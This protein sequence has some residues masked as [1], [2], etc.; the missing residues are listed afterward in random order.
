MEQQFT[1]S[2]VERMTGATRQQLDY[3]SR[4]R[5]VQPR[6]RWGE[7]FFNFS[8]LVAVEA[9]RRLTAQRVP[10]QRLSRVVRALERQ[11]G[12]APRPLSSLHISVTGDE[13]IVR[14]P[15]PNGRPIE[16][17]T[18]QFVLDFDTAPLEK[19]VHLL[20]SRTAEEWFELAMT[21]DGNKETMDKAVEAY[22]QVIQIAPDW[23]EAHINLGTALFHLG[24]WEESR[25]A[26]C[27][28][29]AIDRSHALAH[30]NLGCI[31]DRLGETERAIEEFRAALACAPDM[32]EAHLNLALAYEKSNYKIESKRHFSAYLRYEPQGDWAEFARKR[33]HPDSG[34]RRRRA[35]KVTPFRRA[36]SPN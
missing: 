1:R 25:H 11:L 3:W 27:T 20:G 9:L 28:A 4:L 33:L 15:G 5:L 23:I 18:G 24:R 19:K 6:S 17:L 26:F 21:L 14:E 2:E 35:G 16:P 29:V 7:R 36:Q 10:A 8:D 32:A 22:R 12:S 13:V 31:C 30:F 34:A